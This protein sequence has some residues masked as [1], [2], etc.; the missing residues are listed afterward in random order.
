MIIMKVFHLQELKDIYQS[1]IKNTEKD[2]V[3]F[4]PGLFRT[5]Y[6]NDG[7]I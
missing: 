5:L 2:Q 1:K 7:T 4:E 3:N 6:I